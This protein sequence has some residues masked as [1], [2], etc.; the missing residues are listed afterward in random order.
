MLPS[1]FGTI[2]NGEQPIAVFVGTKN[3][4]DCK[5]YIST[6]TLSATDGAKYRIDCLG[7]E[8]PSLSLTVR[9]YTFKPV[10]SKAPNSLETNSIIR[11][12]KLIKSE[13]E[14]FN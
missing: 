8:V 12:S 10:E 4:S 1:G 7:S 6:F 14:S 3:P 13:Q 11:F 9:G 2:T 5:R